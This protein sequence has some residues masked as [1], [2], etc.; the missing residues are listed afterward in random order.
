MLFLSVGIVDLNYLSL[1]FYL[2]DVSSRHPDLKRK[3]GLTTWRPSVDRDIT[4]S[5]GTYQDFLDSSHAQNNTKL[6]EG[7]WPPKESESL[8]L[9]RWSVYESYA[10]SG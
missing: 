10:P 8:N 4:T 3:P 2:V 7:H 9:D 6:T 1:D 5:Y